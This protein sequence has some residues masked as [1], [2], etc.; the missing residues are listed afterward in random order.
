MVRTV[1]K[2]CKSKNTPQINYSASLTQ[3]HSWK[4]EKDFSIVLPQFKKSIYI[5]RALK[6]RP[7]LTR[8]DG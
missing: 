6:S 5:K 4:A 2:F 7:A 3:N 8:T 1:D